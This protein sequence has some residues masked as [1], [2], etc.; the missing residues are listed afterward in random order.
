M[1]LGLAA[2]A[3]YAVLRRGIGELLLQSGT[4]GT[5]L[6][7]DAAAEHRER[8]RAIIAAA[9]NLGTLGPGW[10]RGAHERHVRAKLPRFHACLAGIRSALRCE[11]RALR[12][13]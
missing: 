2:G 7:G 5:E 4:P 1:L 13:V 3:A 6:A 12:Y 9:K 11:Q 10:N 8:A